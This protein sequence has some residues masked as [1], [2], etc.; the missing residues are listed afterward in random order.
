MVC[1]I[2]V[3][4]WHGV[5]YTQLAGLSGAARAGTALGMANTAVFVVCFLVPLAIPHLLSVQ[6]WSLVWAC[7]AACA[8][9]AMRLLAGARTP[10]RRRAVDG[11]PR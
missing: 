7:A 5:A 9:G 4:A 8:A 3:S 11:C 6:G 1:G 2:C 10:G